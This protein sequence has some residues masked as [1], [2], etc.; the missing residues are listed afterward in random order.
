MEAP[1][2]QDDRICEMEVPTLQNDSSVLCLGYLTFIQD[3]YY[4]SNKKMGV[5]KEAG[6]KLTL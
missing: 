5:L 2:E 1:E 4:G 6:R 3:W